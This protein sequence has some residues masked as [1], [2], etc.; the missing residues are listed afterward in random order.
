MEGVSHSQT[1]SGESLTCH[2][3]GGGGVSYEH[4]P[5]E[6]RGRSEEES[7]LARIHSY[8]PDPSVDEGKKSPL[9]NLKLR[10][11]SGQRAFGHLSSSI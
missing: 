7:T 9:A 10:W 4:L 8:I 3:S 11:S 5:R 6:W 1:L 2:E